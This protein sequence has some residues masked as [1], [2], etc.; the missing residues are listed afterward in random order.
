MIKKVSNKELIYSF[1]QKDI[2]LFAYHIGDL[3]DY[4]FSDCTYF[5]LFNDDQLAEVI[6]FYSGLSTP[7][8]LIFG[9]SQLSIL[10]EGII[11]DL[12]DKFY[13]HYQKGVETPILSKYKLRYFGTHL[14]MRYLGLPK[15]LKA[16]TH[17][18]IQLTDDHLGDILDFYRRANP[19]TYF[20]SHMLRTEKY[21]AVIIKNEIKSIAGVHVFSK[22][23][24]C[25][26]LG[27]VATLPSSRGLGYATSCVIK[28]LQSLEKDVHHIGLNVQANNLAGI[29]LYQKTGFIPFSEYE[30]AYFEKIVYE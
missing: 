8:L 6:L 17:Q 23:Y 19:D 7:V 14:K 26:V 16:K 9:F 5:G 3:D 30:E 22:N 25:A 24:N 12:P 4:F 11:D 1:L 29:N 15:A 28:L 18:C 27:N 2:H 10:L 20:E 13:C 21:Y